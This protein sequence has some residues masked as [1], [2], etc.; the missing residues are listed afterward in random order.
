MEFDNQNDLLNAIANDIQGVVD[1]AANAL[2]AQMIQHVLD[3]VYRPYDD[4]VKRYQ[5][6]YFGGGFVGS[7]T[8]KTDRLG[9]QTVSKIFSD[10]EKMVLDS[11]RYVHGMSMDAM[12]DD[13]GIAVLDDRDFG[14]EVDRRPNMAAHI[15]EGTGYDFALPDDVMPKGQQWWRYPRDYFNPVLSMLKDGSFDKMVK[16]IFNS[17]GFKIE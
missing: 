3:I 1:S 7:W 11:E 6:H 8:V 17:S 5:R 14:F 13:L 15:A 9:R 2:N 10:P 16:N 12:N 4:K